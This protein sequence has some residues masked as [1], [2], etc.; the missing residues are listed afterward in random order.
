MSEPR[1][2]V[3]TTVYNRLPGLKLHLASLVLQK[4]APDFH[5]VVADDGS[6]ADLTAYVLQVAKVLPVTYLRVPHG[7]PLLGVRT[8]NM[9]CAVVPRETTHIWLTDADIVFNPNAV[10]GAYKHLREEPNVVIAGRYDWMPNMAVTP[11]DLAERFED[12]VNCRLPRLPM[13]PESQ[14]GAE[15]LPS[16]ARADPRT[17]FGV[18][19][20]CVTTFDCKGATLGSNLIVPIEAW[21]QTGGYDEN[22]PPACNAGDAEFGFALE[23][24][25]WRNIHCDHIAGYHLYHE[26]N[27]LG[28]TLGVRKGI[29]YI[30]QKYGVPFNPKNLP[31]LPEGVT[32]EWSE[33]QCPN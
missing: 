2:T 9:G 25:G 8:R 23:K 17:R 20:D 16:G 12:F 32:D 3:V 19:G 22:M 14:G 33:A 5:V 13:K 7:D 1:I 24:C 18:W 31:E 29:A 11:E 6:E 15:E 10:F 27:I 30:C 21:K 28:L 26:R 4:D